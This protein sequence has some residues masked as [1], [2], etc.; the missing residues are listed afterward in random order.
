MNII[1]PSI[2]PGSNSDHWEPGF[3]E[4]IILIIMLTLYWS[5]ALSNFWPF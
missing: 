4:A 2:P 3:K 1:P 5:G